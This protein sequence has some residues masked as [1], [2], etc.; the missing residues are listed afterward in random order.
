M[1]TDPRLSAGYCQHCGH[2][3]TRSREFP[4]FV[5]CVNTNCQAHGEDVLRPPSEVR[6]PIGAP[7][8]IKRD[9][10]EG[11]R[12]ATVGASRA[13]AHADRVSDGWQEA[14]STAF[15]K[16]AEAHAEPFITEDVRAANPQ[17]TAP[18]DNRAWGHIARS[19]SLSGI[20]QKV[21]T[22]SA[23][24]PGVH[25]TITTLWQSQIFT[26]RSP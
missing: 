18:P 19:A 21:G 17:L 10:A 3:V 6:A 11:A 2:E 23:K 1:T 15:R 4:V 20:V 12:R 8:P 25:R 5:T 26:R 7:Q 22:R 14:A 9:A 13:A 16:F 24:A